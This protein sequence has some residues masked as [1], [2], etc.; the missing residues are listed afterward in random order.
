M[1]PI[2]VLVGAA[3]EATKGV[4][5]GVRPVPETG[6][7][8][9]FKTPAT[10]F[11]TSGNGTISAGDVVMDIREGQAIEIAPNT[12]VDVMSPSLV[13]LICVAK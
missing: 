7:H 13:L 4:S 2:R 6:L 8:L 3:V 9:S 5:R 10:I 1:S 12:P 11:V